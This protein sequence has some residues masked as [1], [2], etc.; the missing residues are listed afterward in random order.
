MNPGRPGSK[1]FDPGLVFYSA[2]FLAILRI[3]RQTA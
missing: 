3:S 2:S 1:R